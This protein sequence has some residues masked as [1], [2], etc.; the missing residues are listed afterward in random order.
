MIVMQSVKR[1][2]GRTYAKVSGSSASP[3]VKTSRFN[4]LGIGWPVAFALS[5]SSIYGD[6]SS[7]T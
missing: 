6:S 1:D 7:S 2:I 5:Q 3:S 4:G